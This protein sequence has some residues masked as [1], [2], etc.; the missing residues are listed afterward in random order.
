MARGHK[1]MLDK[2]L[3]LL[4]EVPTKAL[5]QAVRRNAVRFPEDFMLR[6]TTEEPQEM[7][8]QFVTASGQAG[9]MQPQ[10]ATASKRHVRYRPYPFTELSLPAW[11]FVRRNC[12]R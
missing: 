1:V 8:S 2:D 9:D 5:N 12:R 6:L 7:R 11:L 3:A 10:S 4:Y